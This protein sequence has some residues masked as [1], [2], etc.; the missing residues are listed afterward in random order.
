MRV[1]KPMR[2]YVFPGG[3]YPEPVT[4]WRERIRVGEDHVILLTLTKRGRL[5][6]ASRDFLDDYLPLRM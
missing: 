2:G 4:I 3:R 5:T 6:K 1:L